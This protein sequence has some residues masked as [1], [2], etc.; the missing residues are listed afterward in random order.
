MP[1]WVRCAGPHDVDNAHF[2]GGQ[3]CLRLVW[4]GTVLHFWPCYALR[5]LA[6]SGQFL[7][8]S[9]PLALYFAI[10]AVC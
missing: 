9:R 1:A 4:I 5:H 8:D 6:E 10:M 7:I 3:P 2:A